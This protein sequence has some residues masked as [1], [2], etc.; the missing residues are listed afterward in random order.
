MLHNAVILAGGKSSRMGEDKALLPFGGYPTMAEYQYRKLQE[1][2]PNVY[3]SAKENKFDFDVDIIYDRY[4]QSSPMVAI[5]S[6]LEELQEDFFLLSVDMPL[7]SLD[8][9]KKLLNV[10]NKENFYEI[11][12][13]E[14]ADGIAPTASIYTTKI[15]PTV[16]ELLKNQNHKLKR[17]LAK[18][19]VKSVEWK[20]E[21]EFLNVNRKE[22]YL[23]AKENINVK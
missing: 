2:F 12:T 20:E 14:S 8:A 13:L 5:A 17:L 21:R 4:S 11:Y 1:I 10:Y 22:Q 3:M 19:R 18:Q 9:I 15:A 6:I 23:Y 16:Q 7:L